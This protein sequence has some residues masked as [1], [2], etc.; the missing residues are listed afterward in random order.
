MAAYS[1]TFEENLRRCIR[2]FKAL[3]PLT[4]LIR[5]PV[6]SRKR[7]TLIPHR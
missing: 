4:H 3:D 1:H 5:L 7:E 6:P 2:A